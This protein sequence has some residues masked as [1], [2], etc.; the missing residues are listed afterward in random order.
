MLLLSFAIKSRS[1]CDS[2]K[3]VAKTLTS[4]GFKN[5]W[6]VSDGFSGGR[7]WL[8]SRLG[9]DSYNFAVPEIVSASRIIPISAGRTG[10]SVQPAQK[11]LLP[12][13]GD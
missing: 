13:S 11:L 7:G 5:T 3:T 1:Y 4:L 2:A 9:T 6:T 8:Q 12:G 10:T